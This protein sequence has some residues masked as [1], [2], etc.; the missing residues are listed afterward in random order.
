MFKQ[1]LR[2]VCAWI[3]LGRKTDKV[4]RMIAREHYASMKYDLKHGDGHYGTDKPIW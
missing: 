4:G 1:V 2:V 3:Q